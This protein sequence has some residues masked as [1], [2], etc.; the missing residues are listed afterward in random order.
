MCGWVCVSVC[1]WGWLGVHV[2][3]WVTGWVCAELGGRPNLIDSLIVSAPRQLLRLAS[4][5]QLRLLIA[6]DNGHWKENAHKLV[7]FSSFPFIARGWSTSG[8]TPL[9]LAQYQNYVTCHTLCADWLAL[10]VIF[11]DCNPLETFYHIVSLIYHASTHQ[12]LAT[13]DFIAPCI[14]LHSCLSHIMFDI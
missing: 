7:F 1:V 2:R 13:D 14:H 10:H 9:L 8:G 12:M 5:V 6:A 3:G 11:D 4:S